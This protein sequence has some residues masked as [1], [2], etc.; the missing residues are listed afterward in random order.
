MHTRLKQ[1]MIK[2]SSEKLASGLC[3][4]KSPS[5]WPPGYTALMHAVD[6]GDAACLKVLLEAGA[7]TEC[8]VHTN[9]GRVLLSHSSPIPDTQDDA[10]ATPLHLA[11]VNGWVECVE[12]LVAHG[13]PVECRDER[14]WPPLLYAHFQNHQECVLAL[15]RAN[16]KQ[17]RSD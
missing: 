5:S 4:L 1:Q 10:G 3:C 13:H 7:S 2:V 14:G 17:V 16:P 9:P 12:A 15:M 11:A 8:K 6:R